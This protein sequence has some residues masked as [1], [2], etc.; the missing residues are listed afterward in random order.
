MNLYYESLL[1]LWTA[2]KLTEAMLDAAINKGWIT[3]DDKEKIMK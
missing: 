1:R 3:E 2:G